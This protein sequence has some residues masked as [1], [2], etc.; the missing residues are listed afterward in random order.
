MLLLKFTYQ[1]RML[2][3]ELPKNVNFLSFETRPDERYLIRLEHQYGAGEDP[4]LSKPVVIN[5]NKVYIIRKIH[6]NF[7]NIIFSI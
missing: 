4:E 1:T 3:D 5:L 7:Q 2:N 6:F